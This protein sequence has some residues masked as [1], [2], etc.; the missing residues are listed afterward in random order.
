MFLPPQ[1]QTLF[2]ISENSDCWQKCTVLPKRVH[3]FFKEKK[4]LLSTCICQLLQ[5]DIKGGDL[6]T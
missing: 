5:G 6:M 3:Y 4:I 2:F 1:P